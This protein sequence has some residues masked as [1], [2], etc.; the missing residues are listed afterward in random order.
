[1]L[2]HS[3]NVFFTVLS[4]VNFYHVLFFWATCESYVELKDNR[5]VCGRACACMQ[6]CTTFT[7]EIEMELLGFN[8]QKHF[9]QKLGCCLDLDSSLS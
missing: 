8:S 7:P 9:F 1:M 4:A 5:N 3:M 2:V 6:R